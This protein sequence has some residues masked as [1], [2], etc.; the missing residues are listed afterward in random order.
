MK[1]YLTSLISLGLLASFTAPVFAQSSVLGSGPE[2]L[3][4]EKA[5][6]GYAGSKDD[7][8][9]CNTALAS[10]LSRVNRGATHN[11]RGILL[12]RKGSLETARKDFES[13]I[14]LRPELIEVQINLAALLMR[15]NDTNGAL[16]ALNT[17]ISSQITTKRAVA[18]YN[19]SIIHDERQNHTQAYQ[20]LKAAL[21]INPDWPLAAN[22]LKDYEVINKNNQEFITKASG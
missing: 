21:E 17:A 2:K 14:E 10:A 16:E 1:H 3:C 11:N 13:A 22:A 8:D 15:M 4:Y 9:V 6:F 12:M 5:L 7:I 18:L 19:R 20:D